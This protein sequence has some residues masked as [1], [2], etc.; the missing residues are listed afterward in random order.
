M[1]EIL[2]RTLRP[3]QEPCRSRSRIPANLD[4]LLSWN[5]AR[6]VTGASVTSV[7]SGVKVFETALPAL[8]RPSTLQRGYNKTHRISTKLGFL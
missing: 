7:S 3:E 1:G 8:L 5:N 2:C 4:L 6:R